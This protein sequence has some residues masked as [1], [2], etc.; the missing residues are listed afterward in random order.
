MSVRYLVPGL[1]CLLG[2]DTTGTVDTEKE[3]EREREREREQE[4]EREREREQEREQDR[5]KER[6]KPIFSC[7]LRSSISHY[8]TRL[9]GWSVCM[10]VTS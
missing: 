1:T 6:V 7:V 2:K 3:R 5:E 8:V 4:Q 9:V 10:S